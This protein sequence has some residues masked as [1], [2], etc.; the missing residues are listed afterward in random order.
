METPSANSRSRGTRLCGLTPELFMMMIMVVLMII[1]IIMIVCLFICLFVCCKK[2]KKEI[3][4]FHPNKPECSR[5]RTIYQR[6]SNAC[7]NTRRPPTGILC[8]VL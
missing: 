3:E 6:S 2:L 8:L 1:I 5:S 7:F 4:E